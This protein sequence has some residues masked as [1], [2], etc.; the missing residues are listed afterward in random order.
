MA[1][2]ILDLLEFCGDDNNRFRLSQPFVYE[3]YAYCT[4]SAIV[5]RISTDAPNSNN[6]P[7]ERKR[8]FPLRSLTSF[9]WRQRDSRF[10][11][12]MKAPPF[13][14]IPQ[15]STCLPCCGSGLFSGY[16]C[17]DC[18]GH[19][20]VVD[21]YKVQWG[22]QFIDARYDFLLRYRDHFEWRPD[23]NNP[24]R[25]EFRFDGADGYLMVLGDAE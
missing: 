21:L 17:Y 16:P 12:W 25:I 20:S 5:I 14:P 2:L 8:V 19:G 13:K 10:K 22:D 18:S 15:E 9:P 24:S 3:G 23:R 4:D 6:K 7:D 11:G 1:E